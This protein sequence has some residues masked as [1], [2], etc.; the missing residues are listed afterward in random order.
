MR[1]ACWITDATDIRSEYVILISFP[2]QERYANA[3]QYYVIGT[4]SF[5]FLSSESRAVWRITSRCHYTHF[6]QQKFSVRVFMLLPRC[7]CAAYV[8][9][10]WLPT[11]RDSISIP[12]QRS[13]ILLEMLEYQLRRPVHHG[14][15]D[16]LNLIVMNFAQWFHRGF[17]S[18]AT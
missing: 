3:P 12:L 6:C 16:F 15:E 18:A 11:F 8:F 10:R 9:C 7:C 14:R 4:L 2:R 5:L 13:Y 1:F 17:V